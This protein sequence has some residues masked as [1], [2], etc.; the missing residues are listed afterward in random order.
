MDLTF[1]LQSMT[2]PRH[3]TP[4]SLPMLP[5]RM[6]NAEAAVNDRTPLILGGKKLRCSLVGTAH[7]MDE[8]RTFKPVYGPSLLVYNVPSEATADKI[9]EVFGKVANVSNVEISE[10][11]AQTSL[12]AA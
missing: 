10:V 12:L 9:T 8:H 3:P 7:R 2:R 5:C 4:H 1:H 6:Q 11:L